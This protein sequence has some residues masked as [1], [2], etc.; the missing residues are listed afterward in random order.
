MALLEFSLHGIQPMEISPCWIQP[1]V[2]SQYVTQPMEFI[3][4][5]YVDFKKHTFLE[6]LLYSI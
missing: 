2:F 1:T 5:L 4:L 3:P 6:Y